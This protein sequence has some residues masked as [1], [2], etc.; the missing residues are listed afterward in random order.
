MQAGLHIALGDPLVRGK[1]DAA[2]GPGL[3]LWWIGIAALFVVVIPLV[4]F[5]AVRL[6]LV[7]HEIEQYADDVLVHGLAIT[8]N[9]EPVPA[10]LETRELVKGVGAGLVEYAAAVEKIVRDGR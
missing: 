4:L 1:M 2:S 9:L 3:I 5:L 6:L 7:V 10:L 8:K